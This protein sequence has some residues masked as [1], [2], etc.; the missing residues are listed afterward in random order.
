[1]SCLFFSV[2]EYGFLCG[3]ESC[4]RI[5]KPKLL[6]L[7]AQSNRFSY[8]ETFRFGRGYIFDVASINVK[9]VCV[10]VCERQNRTTQCNKLYLKY[11]L[12]YVIVN[13]K[14]VPYFSPRITKSLSFSLS[15]SVFLI[16]MKAVNE[17]WNKQF[18]MR[19]IKINAVN[20]GVY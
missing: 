6:L 19:E 5:N 3:F 15:L 8:P 14:Y 9:C 13:I 10:C 4:W 17:I 7:I 2:C 1:M 18:F 12:Q 11:T 16:S 20:C